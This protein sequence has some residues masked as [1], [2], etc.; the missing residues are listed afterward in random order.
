MRKP[1][2]FLEKAGD[3]WLDDFVYIARQPLIERGYDIVAFDGSDMENTL[4]NKRI[5]PETDLIVG[6]VEATVAWFNE[7]GIEVPKALGYPDSLRPYLGRE[8]IDTTFGDLDNDFPY[9][10]KPSTQVKLFTGDVVSK[11]EH[12]GYLRDSGAVD[13]TP[14]HK[15]TLINFLSEYRCFVMSGQ[16]KGIQFYKGDFR[17]L[18]DV[19]EIIK[20]IGDYYNSGKAPSCFTL[21]VG[22][23]RKMPTSPLVN[24]QQTRLVEVNDFWAIGSYGFNGKDYALMCA[25]RMKEIYNNSLK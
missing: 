11:K 16:L 23:V 4:L 12:L 15:S 13:S 1:I 19:K 8:I 20:M 10:V 24:V 9:F 17:I 14:L 21:D 7:C 18:P 25:R 22:V 6:S 5:N 3:E 2:A